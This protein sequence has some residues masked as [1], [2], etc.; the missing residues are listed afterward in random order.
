LFNPVVECREPLE[1]IYHKMNCGLHRRDIVQ[2]L[3]D[4]NVLSREILQELPYDSCQDNLPLYSKI[5]R[6]CR[7]R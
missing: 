1:K 7:K 6:G 4:A 5:I 2:L 3:Y